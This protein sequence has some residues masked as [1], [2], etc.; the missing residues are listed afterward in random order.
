MD[1]AIS[2]L[3]DFLG[4]CAC[5][6]FAG[7]GIFGLNDLATGVFDEKKAVVC[8]VFWLMGMIPLGIAFVQSDKFRRELRDLKDQ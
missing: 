7:L 8:S 1:H 2:I 6:F 4:L 3:I 5:L